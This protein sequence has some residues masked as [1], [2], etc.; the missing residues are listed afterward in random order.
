MEHW[1]LG[2]H[3]PMLLKNI[4]RGQSIYAT[5]WWVL[6]PTSS[7][8]IRTIFLGLASSVSNCDGILTAVCSPS[9]PE[10]ATF[11]TSVFSLFITLLYWLNWKLGA[12]ACVST[13]AM[14][15][16]APEMLPC[17]GGCCHNCPSPILLEGKLGKRSLLPLTGA[18]GLKPWPKLP[19]ICWLRGTLDGGGTFVSCRGSLSAALAL[20]QVAHRGA[21]AA[22]WALAAA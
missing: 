22:P 12:P 20:E 1:I 19:N 4:A 9:F 15:D 11:N 14:L 8:E 16:I 17:R 18:Q 21:V 2:R 7:L 6:T 13:N 5:C 3:A 10:L